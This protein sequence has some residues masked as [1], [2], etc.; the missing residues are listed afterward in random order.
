MN[1]QTQAT[2]P[3]DRGAM[4]AHFEAGLKA[5]ERT[6][7][8]LEPREEIE[9][10]LCDV[11]VV[12]R[13]NGDVVFQIFPK[14]KWPMKSKDNG[15]ALLSQMVEVYFGDTERFSASW[16]PELKSWALRARGLRDVVSYDRAHHVVGFAAFINQALADL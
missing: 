8:A 9:G 10:Q 13:E 6:E 4:L 5:F 1:V 15:R 14:R 3:L 7:F 11:T 16:V 2:P 12:D